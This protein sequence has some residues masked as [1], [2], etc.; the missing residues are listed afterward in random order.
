MIAAMTERIRAAVKEV[1]SAKA[2]GLP[3]GIPKSCKIRTLNA[4]GPGIKIAC[5]GGWR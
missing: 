3:A 2:A 1:Y 4:E 5:T